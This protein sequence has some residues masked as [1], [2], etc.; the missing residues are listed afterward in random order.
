[1]VDDRPQADRILVA[2]FTGEARFQ[3]KWRNLTG[4]EESSSSAIP[5][6]GAA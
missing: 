3:A 6:S 1:M 4:A 2:K 5:I